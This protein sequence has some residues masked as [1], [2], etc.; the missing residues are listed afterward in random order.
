MAA[1]NGHRHGPA[2]AAAH[3]ALTAQLCAMSA[4]TNAE[5]ADRMATRA[6]RAYAATESQGRLIVRV[7]AA[8]ALVS[9]L[10]LLSSVGIW[11][12]AYFAR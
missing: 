2:G 1:V 11:F 5:H 10:A 9:V 12:W 4:R 7:A 3:H 8:W 6:E